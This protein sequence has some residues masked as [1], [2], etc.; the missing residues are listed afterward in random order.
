MKE[1]L[2]VP[3]TSMSKRKGYETIERD[4]GEKRVR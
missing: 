4:D 2:N 3:F 1:N